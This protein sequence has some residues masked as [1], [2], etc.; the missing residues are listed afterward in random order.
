M[1]HYP[2]GLACPWYFVERLK[3]VAH[4]LARVLRS[5][6]ASED[7]GQL[8]S[9][10][11]DFFEIRS[12]TQCKHEKDNAPCPYCR[13]NFKCGDVEVRWYKHL[14]RDTVINREITPREAFSIFSLCLH[15]IWELEEVLYNG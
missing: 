4:E 2:D 7:V 9:F 12:Y 5:V 3:F 14:G 6:A 1:P 10:E 13:P 11:N 8:V 15:S